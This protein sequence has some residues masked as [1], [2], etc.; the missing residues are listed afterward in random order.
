MTL[1]QRHVAETACLLMPGLFPSS[2]LN[3]SNPS[4]PLVIPAGVSGNPV[5]CP[6]RH[7]VGY[8]QRPWKDMWPVT[9]NFS[10][11]SGL[12]SCLTM[13]NDMSQKSFDG[14][15]Q[16]LPLRTRMV[17]V[18][19]NLYK[20][21]TNMPRVTITISDQMLRLCRNYF[22]RRSSTPSNFCKE[23]G[24]ELELNRG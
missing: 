6:I 15:R 11:S 20:K 1:G 3:A 21:E 5:S 4:H 10:R 9:C 13:R 22:C 23:W 14:R 19:S 12:D 17:G 7:E 8:G 16:S 2:A 18:S 24:G